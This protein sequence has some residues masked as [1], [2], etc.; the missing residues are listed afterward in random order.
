MDDTTFATSE[1]FELFDLDDELRDEGAPL[2][3]GGGLVFY[4]RPASYPPFARKYNDEI[5][6]LKSKYRQQPPTEA[7]KLIL[8]KTVPQHLI[9][10]W[11]GQIKTPDGVFHKC[12]SPA[13]TQQL[14]GNRRGNAILRLILDFAETEE[15]YR[16]QELE[17]VAGKL[18]S[19]SN[20]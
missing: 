13:K 17:E 18:R 5:L 19:V 6:K 16:K 4:V 3:L 10:R 8:Q 9:V 12:E 7:I 11:T 15:N 20:V 14:L 1:A 2:D